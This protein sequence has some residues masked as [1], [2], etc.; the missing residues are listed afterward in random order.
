MLVSHTSK[1]WC[2]QQKYVGALH[3]HICVYVEDRTCFCWTCGN[4]MLSIGCSGEVGNGINP[5][6]ASHV[7]GAHESVILDSPFASVPPGFGRSLG[8]TTSTGSF[9]SKSW[10]THCIRSRGLLSVCPSEMWVFGRCLA[11]LYYQP[12]FLLTGASIFWIWN[13]KF[14]VGLKRWF[15]GNQLAWP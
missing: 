13:F 1:Y 14:E 3:T 9:P 8:K 7:N 2:A 10:S 5:V 12:H 4:S 11:I 15:R 6:V